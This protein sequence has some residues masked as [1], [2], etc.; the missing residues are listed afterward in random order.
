M[1]AV[2]STSPGFTS[3]LASTKFASAGLPPQ[4]DYFVDKVA[5]ASIWTVLITILAMGIAY[6]Q[7]MSLPYCASHSI[8]YARQC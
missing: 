5:S 2:N 3:V 7:S 6:D 8:A 1:D 4:F